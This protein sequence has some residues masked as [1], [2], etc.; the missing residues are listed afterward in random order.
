MSDWG[1][2]EATV[3]DVISRAGHSEM[4]TD[5]LMTGL[6]AEWKAEDLKPTHECSFDLEGDGCHTCGIPYEEWI[7]LDRKL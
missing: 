1:M 6:R 7:R 2:M 4:L 3:R 5:T